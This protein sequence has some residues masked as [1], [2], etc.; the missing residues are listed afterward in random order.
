V[1]KIPASSGYSRSSSFYEELR[2][3]RHLMAKP[4]PPY[5]SSSKFAHTSINVIARNTS[6]IVDFNP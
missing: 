3:L 1:T 4:E 6:T 5:I 2:T